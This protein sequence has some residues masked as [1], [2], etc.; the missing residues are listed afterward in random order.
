MVTNALS[1]K[2]EDLATA[3]EKIQT[4]QK[5][6]IINPAAILKIPAIP[7]APYHNNMAVIY[8]NKTATTYPNKTL[9]L[10]E[11]KKPAGSLNLA[12]REF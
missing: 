9:N 8:L 10:S 2:Q 11:L 3:R 6:R 1:R 12:S 7:A 4:N 5:G